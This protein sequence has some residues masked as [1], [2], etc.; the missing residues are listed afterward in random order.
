MVDP[1][2]HWKTSDRKGKTDG[3]QVEG[4]IWKK[5][6]RGARFEGEILGNCKI[7]L[8]NTLD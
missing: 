4:Y 7:R 6:H 2:M 5:P 3:G 1:G 8:T